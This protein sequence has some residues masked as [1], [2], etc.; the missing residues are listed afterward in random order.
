MGSGKNQYADFLKEV[1]N[2]QEY[3]VEFDLY[4]NDL[5]KN[6]SEDFKL[7]QD[8]INSKIDSISSTLQSYFDVF[9]R[10]SVDAEHYIVDELN[11]LKFYDYNFFEDKTII[12]RTLLQLYGTEIFRNRFKDDYWLE[13]L[14]NR[15]NK[16]DADVIIVTDTRF[17]NELENMYDYVK[18]RRIVPIRIERDINIREG[19]KEH[20]SETGL[21]NYTFWEY[22]V[23]NNGTLEDLKDSS[24]WVCNDILTYK[25]Y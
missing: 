19:N 20:P 5:K 13:L 23:D 24:K 12:T 3:S 21:D 8:V 1:F 22:I 2:K 25:D 4:A 16:S 10:I 11:K 15:I 7:L 9:D 6:A 18:D 17:V 14:A